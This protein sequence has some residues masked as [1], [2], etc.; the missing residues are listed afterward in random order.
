MNIKKNCIQNQIS[1][2]CVCDFFATSQALPID[3]Y[4]FLF[5]K[6]NFNQ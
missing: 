3:T 6:K 5:E 2:V 1:L 4:F